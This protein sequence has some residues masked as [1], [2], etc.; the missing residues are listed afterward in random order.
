MAN[1]EPI[2]LS[3]IAIELRTRSLLGLLPGTPSVLRDLS[4]KFIHSLL[5]TAHDFRMLLGEIGLLTDIVAQIE[6]HDLC[7][8]SV[9]VLLVA[10][11]TG[12]LH[13]QF[14][15]ALTN[16]FNLTLRRVVQKLVAR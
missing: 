11:T 16:S 10:P 1:S 8:R 15:V 3:L 2:G 7:R 6:E 14:P 9:G 12:L 13:Q 4:I 5:E